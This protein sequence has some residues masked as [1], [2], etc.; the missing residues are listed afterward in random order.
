MLILILYP[1]LENSTTPIAITCTYTSICGK[2]TKGEVSLLTKADS[3][4]VVLKSC[5]ETELSLTY[6]NPLPTF[7]S[8]IKG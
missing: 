5:S 8:H 2:M 1:S 6:L 3:E 7:A 4:T